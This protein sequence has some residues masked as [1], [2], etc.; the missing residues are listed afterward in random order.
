MKKRLMAVV[1]T[2]ALAASM[3]A[4]CGGSG[5]SGSDGGSEANVAVFWYDES[6]VYLGTVR[7]ALNSELEELG[8]TYQDQFASNTQSTQMEQIKTAL[9]AGVNLLV[10]NVVTS[11]NPDQAQEIIDL[12]GDVP[13]I[14]FN[15]AIGT[16]GSDVEVLEANENAGF[17]GT[18][19]PKAGLSLIH[20]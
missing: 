9:S 14:F 20:I 4:G 1:L 6:D 2:L 8:I 12:A 5:D 16:E 7:D 13:V 3:I 10:V 18:D 17:I 11:G 19:A 15:R